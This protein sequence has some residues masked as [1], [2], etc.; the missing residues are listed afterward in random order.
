ARLNSIDLFA[1]VAGL[2][3]AGAAEVVAGAE[4]GI[5]VVPAQDNV[6]TEATNINKR[7]IPDTVDA[8]FTFFIINA[9]Y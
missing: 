9:S 7:Q 4:V 6:N 8:N 5:G 2:A 3:G 1:G